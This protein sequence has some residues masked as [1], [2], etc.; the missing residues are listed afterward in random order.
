MKNTPIVCTGDGSESFL[1]SSVPNLQFAHLASNLVHFKPKIDSNGGEVVINEVVVAV[2]DEEGRLADSL[3][4]HDDNFEEKI[5]LFDH[6]LLSQSIDQN[7]NYLQVLL[8][9]SEMYYWDMA[10]NFANNI[11]Q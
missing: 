2:P 4:A 11:T 6:E 1:S 7:G 3:V 5:L 10:K 9:N 8:F